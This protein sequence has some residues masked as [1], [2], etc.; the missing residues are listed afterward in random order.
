[1]K[2]VQRFLRFANYF[3]RFILG[4]STVVA[5]LTSLLR[6]GPQRLRWTAERGFETLKARFTTAPVL[7]HPDPSLPFI[8]VV[9]A[10]EVGVRAVLSQCT[11]TS[12]KLQPCAF[13]SKQL[14]PDQRN[15]DLGDRELLAVKKALKVWRHWLDGSKHP[16]LV[17]TDHRNLEYIRAA[18]R[19]NPRQA[20]WALFFTRFQFTISYRPGS[21]NVKVDAPSY[22]YDT[23]ERQGQETPIIPLFRIIAPAVWDVDADI[24]QALH[25]EPAP[26]QCPDNRA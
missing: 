4:F 26:S 2:A 18:K 15:Y 19:L 20:R 1:V 5:P 22:L 16:F 11:G 12:P 25:T 21:K 24:W 14:S 17:W 3:R 13:Y 6:G 23:D 7:A 8:V 10:S 9:D